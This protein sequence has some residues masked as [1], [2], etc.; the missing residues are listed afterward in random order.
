MGKFSHQ[1]I[2]FVSSSFASEDSPSL[3]RLMYSLKFDQKSNFTSWMVHL[4]LKFPNQDK[5]NSI[6]T[7][8]GYIGWFRIDYKV[9]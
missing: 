2:E 5:I 3:T 6:I 4:R 1:N 7:V 9:A 8:E